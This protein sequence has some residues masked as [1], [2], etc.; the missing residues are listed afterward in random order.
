MVLS[1]PNR[2]FDF[3]FVQGGNV[4]ERVVQARGAGWGWGNVVR[5]V[6]HLL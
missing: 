5:I 4:E 2:N 6:I 1:I 3:L